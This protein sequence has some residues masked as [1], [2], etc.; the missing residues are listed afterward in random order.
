MVPSTSANAGDG[1]HDVGRSARLVQERVDRDHALRAP[2]S[3]RRASAR[4]AKS[5]SGSEPSRMS[6]SMLPVGRGF[7]D[8]VGVE[9]GL[10]RDRSPDRR[11]GRRARRRGHPTRK[12][13][14]EPAL[15]R[16]RRGRCPDAAPAGTCASGSA[17]RISATAATTRSADSARL[18]RPT[19]TV[20]DRRPRRPGRPRRELVGR[21][22]ADAVG[23]DLTRDDGPHHGGQLARRGSAATPWRRATA[24]SRSGVSSMMRRPVVRPPRA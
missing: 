12:Q 23:R 24:R 11:P 10:G 1:Q 14:R 7:E 6:T 3:A 9:A 15:P 17:E 18:A 13:A 4:S 20:T 22:S 2:A 21:E 16:A 8:A 19:T 5:A